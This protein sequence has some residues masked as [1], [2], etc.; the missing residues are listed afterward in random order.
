[1]K[2][3]QDQAVSAVIGGSGPSSLSTLGWNSCVRYIG[4]CIN[5]INKIKKI[6]KINILPR[7][8]LAWTLH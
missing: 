8:S 4:T 3:D 5:K 6:K 1:M 7:L 2:R